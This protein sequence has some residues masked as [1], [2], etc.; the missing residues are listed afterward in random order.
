MSGFQDFIVRYF[1]EEKKLFEMI[2]LEREKKRKEIRNLQNIILLAKLQRLTLA[3]IK[4][5]CDL[6]IVL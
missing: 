5:Y 2:Y 1:I 6:N 4:F 3:E